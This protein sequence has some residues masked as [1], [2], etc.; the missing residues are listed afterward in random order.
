MIRLPPRA[1]RTDT[2]FPYTTLFRSRYELGRG[3][4]EGV[5]RAPIDERSLRAG[6]VGRSARPVVEIERR[7]GREH[8]I[9]ARLGR[10][11]R[12]VDAAPRHHR[13]RKS[14]RL[15]SSH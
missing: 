6:L 13:D 5:E 8:G 2:L 3:R 9:V 4:I 10:G 15:N 7:R 11:D 12:A 1:T 14:T